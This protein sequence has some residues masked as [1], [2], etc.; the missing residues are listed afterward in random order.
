MSTTINKKIFD[1]TTLHDSSSVDVVSMGVTLSGQPELDI[2][3]AALV[4]DSSDNL[5]LNGEDILTRGQVDNAPTEN[6]TNLVTS[7]GVYTALAGKQDTLGFDSS[8]PVEDSSNILTS[9]V[10]YNTLQD[11]ASEDSS[12]NRLRISLLV[13]TCST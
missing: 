3:N 2:G 7:G 4:N 1:M 12:R 5:K 11:Y 10:I 6:S 8:G 9:G 13:S